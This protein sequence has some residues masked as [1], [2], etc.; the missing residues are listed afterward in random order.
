MYHYIKHRDHFHITLSAIRLTLVLMFVP[1][2]SF[3][4]QWSLDQCIDTALQNNLSLQSAKFQSQIAQIELTSSKQDLLPALN[5]GIT[6]GY[7]WGQTI[8]LFTNQFATSRVMYN[9]FYFNSSVTLFSGLQKYYGIQ[10]NKLNIQTQALEQEITERNVKIDVAA[11]FLQVLLNQEIS[12]LCKKITKKTDMQ[13]QRVK[14]L[15]SEKQATNAELLEL[16]AQLA[17]DKYNQI[18]AE[19]DLA[20]STLILQQ[21]L[22]VPVADSFKVS[23]SFGE[24]AT[25]TTSSDSVRFAEIVKIE[26]DIQKQIYLIKSLKGRY[27]PTLMLG[28]SL[29]SGYSENN[30]VLTTGGQLVTRPF[31]EQVND[32][33][34]QSIYASLSIPIFNKNSTRNQ[35]KIQE[36]KL[37]DLDISKQSAN[38]ELEQKLAQLK[39]EI[40]SASAQLEALESV[41]ESASVNFENNVLLFETGSINATELDEVKNKLFEAES[42]LL[43]TKYQLLFKKIIIGFYL[44]P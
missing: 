24:F 38:N 29:G 14:E 16:D 27:Y 6:H 25:N 13:Y 36:L 37:K 8:D 44:E 2:L 12:E 21:V 20:Y 30:K 35:V 40:S 22:N 17:R 32:N 7:N 42:D 43:Q 3:A 18:K 39:M 19:N 34:Y 33:F 15:L 31:Y 1:T 41:K 28:G 10:S 4:Q 11:A 5:G 26:T 23:P 9:N